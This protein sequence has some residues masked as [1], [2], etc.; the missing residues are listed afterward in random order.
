[1]S[2]KQKE[3]TVGYKIYNV[4][5]E[6]ERDVDKEWYE[7]RVTLYQ[8]G[9]QID[10]FDSRL[11]TYNGVQKLNEDSA[12]ESAHRIKEEVEQTQEPNRWFDV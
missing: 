11:E 8:N 12:R 1:M 4:S 3:F 5:E 7:Y 2:Q 9:E 10:E 6:L